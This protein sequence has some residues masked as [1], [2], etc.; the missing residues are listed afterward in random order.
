MRRTLKILNGSKFTLANQTLSNT[1]NPL[2]FQNRAYSQDVI[3]SNGQKV[4]LSFNNV[5]RDLHQ[6]EDGVGGAFHD[7]RL[8]YI[9]HLWGQLYKPGRIEGGGQEPG[10]TTQKSF[11]SYADSL[12][13]THNAAPNS[14]IRLLTRS[15]SYATYALHENDIKL[16]LQY[17]KKYG[18]NIL[19]KQFHDQNDFTEINKLYDLIIELDL[20]IELAI[21]YSCEE[22]YKEF[23]TKKFDEACQIAIRIRDTKK[24]KIINDAN[25]LADSIEIKGSNEEQVDAIARKQKII[26]DAEEKA[27][28]ITAK[29]ST[30]SMI[31]MVHDQNI[32][33]AKWLAGTMSKIAL[34]HGVTDLTLHAHGN[35]PEVYSAFMSVCFHAGIKNVS[36]D[37]VPERTNGNTS[38]STI[39]AT[40]T[41]LN[42]SY[43]IDIRPKGK[44][45]E[46]LSII[47]KTQEERDKDLTKA[48]L[49]VE[50]MF[51]PSN[52]KPLLSEEDKRFMGFPDGA[53]FYYVSKVQASGLL[54]LFNSDIYQTLQIL[55]FV[56]RKVRDDFGNLTGVTP[57][58]LRTERMVLY[59][60]DKFVVNSLNE[61]SKKINKAIK[62][63]SQDD[64]LSYY[65]MILKQTSPESLYDNAPAELIDVFRSGCGDRQAY[66]RVF[67]A[68]M[69]EFICKQHMTNFLQ[70]PKL[71]QLP[72]DIKSTLIENSL[73]K[74]QVKKIL[75]NYF[76]S[77]D[78]DR[79][80]A[81]INKIKQLTLTPFKELPAKIKDQLDESH[82]INESEQILSNYFEQLIDA[83]ELDKTKVTQ[84]EIR[85][86]L[87]ALEYFYKLHQYNQNIADIITKN[88]TNFFDPLNIVG[89]AGPRVYVESVKAEEVGAK[90]KNELFETHNISGENLDKKIVEEILSRT[91]THAVINKGPKPQPYGLT[92]EGFSNAATLHSAETKQRV[93][94]LNHLCAA[95]I[96]PGCI[97]EITLSD[98]DNKAI[99]PFDKKGYYTQL[100]ETQ[101]QEIL[102]AQVAYEK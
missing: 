37:S 95:V 55:K 11:G 68:Q 30:K 20:D 94:N 64:L 27:S 99:L 70:E 87:D 25:K 81:K 39:E 1:F 34:E 50:D 23:F 77:Y 21:P 51:N 54:N 76:S 67:S 65:Q 32:S 86:A 15:T 82:D 14:Q 49:K 48:G 66:P 97:N 74:D 46:I 18:K 31:S 62:D 59:A 26:S 38:F 56:T 91:F 47:A 3:N 19:I 22:D 7:A 89:A 69:K 4:T 92:A 45:A 6:K 72:E 40:T 8:T 58:W 35:I 24:D 9:H 80:I 36:V 61:F 52:Q 93:Q 17:M 100:I 16:V 96:D 57:G 90:I 2:G 43:G 84:T 13:K 42:S 88:E 73:N 78:G 79:F 63:L 98:L 53:L 5:I 83:Q 60:A 10:A 29:A 28:K 12:Q 44:D 33:E 75:E 71:S 85:V 41:H 101:K 102:H